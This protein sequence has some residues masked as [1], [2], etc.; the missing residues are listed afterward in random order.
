MKNKLAKFPFFLGITLIL[1]VSGDAIAQIT[2]PQIAQSIRGQCRAV[3]RS[4][5]LF[6]NRSEA[7][8]IESIAANGRV[9]LQEENKN[10][11]WIAVRSLTTNQTGFV[12]TQDLT[13]CNNPPTAS[14]PPS[15][16]P[17]KP[18]SPQTMQA[19]SGLCRRVIY[20]EGEGVAV[21]ANPNLNSERVGGVLF[22]EIVRINPSQTRL[23]AMG[24]EWVKLNSP[25]VGWMSNGFPDTGSNLG[26]CL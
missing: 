13:S 24:R 25:V 1:M 15:P 6:S 2:P 22:G 18:P 5:F 21:R 11:G 23:D 4:T 16:R 17:S 9:A 20:D 26:V 3:N 14:T 7:N 12:R 10:D 19:N 8:P